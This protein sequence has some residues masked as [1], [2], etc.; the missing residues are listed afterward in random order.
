M[1]CAGAIG[2]LSSLAAQQFDVELRDQAIWALSNIAG[3]CKDC[4]QKLLQSEFLDI[5][6]YSMENETI[7]K[8]IYERKEPSRPR[9]N[10]GID[11]LKTAVWALSNMCRGR[12]CVPFQKMRRFLPTLYWI[13]NNPGKRDD[14]E[15]LTDVCWSLAYLADGTPEQVLSF[16]SKISC[17]D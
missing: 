14:V 1:V 11:S 12:P 2:K 10:M 7:R 13:V 17:I 5:L 8:L 4:R 15:V 9:T 16:F 6:Q 3:D